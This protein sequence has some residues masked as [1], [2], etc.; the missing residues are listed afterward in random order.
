M[1]IKRRVYKNLLFWKKSKDRRPMIIRGA[2]QVGKTTLVR[3]F[4]SEYKVFIELNLERKTDREL[5]N[6]DSVEKI[7]NAAC[8]LKKAAYVPEQTLLFIDE[9][10]EEPNAIKMLRYFYEDMPGLHVITAGSLLEFAMRQVES[11]PVGRVEYL[12]LYPLNFEE[13]LRGIGHEMA[14]EAIGKVP[15][16]DYA[17]SVFT[18]LFHEY[19]IV[20]GMPE[21]VEKYIKNKDLSSLA[22]TYKRLW[23][24]YQ[25]DVEKY[26][27]N[28]TD[29]KTIRHVIDTAPF[30]KDRITFE[31]FGNSNYRSREVGEALR[32]LDRAGLVKLVYPSTSTHPP[33]APDFKK[34]PRLQFL[35]TGMLNQVLMLQGDMLY[36]ND[37]NDFHRG[38]ILQHLV[39]QE[40]IST[41]DDMAWKPNFW[42]REEKD[43]NAEVDIAL[44][45]GKYIIPVEIK[46][47]KQGKLRSLHQFVERSDHPYAVRLGAGKFNVEKVK[48][49]GGTQYLLMNLPYYLACKLP[50]YLKWFVK[51]Y[52]EKL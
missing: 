10:Q 11:Y 28:D 47:G 44:Q 15:V 46:A 21:V 19:A 20:G 43:S 14:M 39:Y 31:R 3:D 42:V 45:S 16:A 18:D 38:R 26:A 30:E 12:Y 27:G 49:P 48:T 37:L 25:D 4:S 32:T 8:L 5:F 52:P 40:I 17:H 1:S 24:A 29:R 2:R 9:I 50:E 35:D 23:Q 41:H 51:N 13:Y 7:F 22:G 6:T 33:L 34:R 36:V